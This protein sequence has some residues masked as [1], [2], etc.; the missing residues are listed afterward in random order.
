M[1]EHKSDG[2]MLFYMYSRK[3]YL[4]PKLFG[5]KKQYILGDIYLF[6]W[7]LQPVSQNYDLGSYTIKDVYL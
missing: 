5:F 6:I 3:I 7:L 2:I 4:T 1:Y